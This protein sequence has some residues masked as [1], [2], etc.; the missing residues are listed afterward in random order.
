M[1][2]RP[3][4]CVLDLHY[5][6]GPRAL[7]ARFEVAVYFHVPFSC[8]SSLHPQSPCLWIFLL[9]QVPVLALAY[10]SNAW[11]GWNHSVPQVRF[12]CFASLDS[13][14]KELLNPKRTWILLKS[15]GEYFQKFQRYYRTQGIL[16]VLLIQPFC[17]VDLS[18]MKDVQVLQY[19][20][21]YRSRERVLLE[22]LVALGALARCSDTEKL[23]AA[24]VPLILPLT[25]WCLQ[26]L[27]PS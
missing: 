11:C 14:Q 1:R 17:R 25:S 16:D 20:D 19:S 9:Q 18:G 2:L 21:C 12:P 24:V 22:P 7:E 13:L 15:A 4:L 8:F 27:N 10:P 26:P 6:F 23:F 3:G 5:C